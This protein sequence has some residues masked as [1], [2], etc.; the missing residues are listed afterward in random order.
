MDSQ[1]ISA[2]IV[3]V[4]TETAED[5]N[6]DSVI[7]SFDY[8]GV[9]RNE[10]FGSPPLDGENIAQ[11]RRLVLS[12]ALDQKVSENDPRIKDFDLYK[13]ELEQKEVY[14]AFDGEEVYALGKNP[15]QMLFPYEYG[16]WQ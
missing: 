2:R 5:M 1:P 16:L 7:V 10:D 14:I 15:K 6:G 8:Q 12:V 3:S 4:V 9:R 11:W 13:K